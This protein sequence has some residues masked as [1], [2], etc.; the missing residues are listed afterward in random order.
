MNI[1]ELV[2]SI[3]P[4]TVIIGVGN[5]ISGDDAFGPALAERI[6]PLFGARCINGGL[7]PENWLGKIIDM[8]PSTL[9]IA[10]A[11]SFDGE[12]GEIRIYKPEDLVQ[13]LP[14]THGPG[15]GPL[16]QYIRK[17]LPEI[18]I[19]IL[20]VQPEITGLMV[21]MS[22]PVEAAIEKI[23]VIFKENPV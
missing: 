7:A 2:K 15:F 6:K 20:A 14:A 22:A 9:I 19:Y 18:E 10:D 16:V 21:P 13:E 3:D 17:F 5:D 1:R 12:P 23:V 8:A 4:N 11:V